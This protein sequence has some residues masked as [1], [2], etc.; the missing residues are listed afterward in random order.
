LS[1]T[2]SRRWPIAL[3]IQAIIGRAVSRSDTMMLLPPAFS[4]RAYLS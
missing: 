4:L 1:F 3:A 2:S